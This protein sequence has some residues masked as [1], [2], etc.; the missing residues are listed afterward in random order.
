M[1]VSNRE[2][3]RCWAHGVAANSHTGNFWTD[4]EK[5]YS[6]N[7]CI[8]DTS[9]KLGKV[10]RDYTAGSDKY[11]YYSQTTSCHVGQARQ[12]ADIVDG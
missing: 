3:P 1:R 10:L 9:G 7:L 6:Y 2:V 11:S 8:G 4:G 5:L 12:W